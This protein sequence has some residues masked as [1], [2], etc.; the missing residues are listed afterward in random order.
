MKEKLL[1]LLETRPFIPFTIVASAGEKHEVGYPTNLAVGKHFATLVG[2]E[3]H[4]HQ[5]IY[6]LYITNFE[7]ANLTTPL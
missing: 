2:P 5:H 6:L 7:V 4:W 1:E 3:T